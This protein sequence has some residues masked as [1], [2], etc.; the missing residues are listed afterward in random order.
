MVERLSTVPWYPAVYLGAAE[1]GHGHGAQVLADGGR[2]IVSLAAGLEVAGL[3]VGDEVFLGPERNVIVARSSAPAHVTGD[4]ASFVRYLPDGRLVV[5]IH[6]QDIIARPAACLGDSLR[7]GALLRWDRTSGL[8][9]EHLDA[10]QSIHDLLEGTPAENF[11]QVGGLQAEIARLTEAM[12]LR[13]DHPSM[14]VKYGLRAPTAGLLVGPPGVGKTLLARAFAN[15]LS[16]RTSE[17]RSRF[18]EV[19]PGQVLSHWFG[20]SETR[21]RDTFAIAKRAAASEPCV[22]IVLFFDEIDALGAARGDRGQRYNDQVL[23]TFLAELSAIEPE[24]GVF[25]L[26]ATNRLDALDPALTRP[27]GRLG[28]LVIKVPRPNRK[29]GRDVLARYLHGDLQFDVTATGG[30]NEAARQLVIDATVSAIYAPNG[31]GALAH[32]TLRDGSRRT[33]GT[34][35]LVSGAV[36][37]SVA[38]TACARAC[39]RELQTGLSGIRP[40]DVVASADEQFAELSA[41][42][43]PANVRSYVE[44]LP[45]DLDPVRVEPVKR[46]VNTSAY[47]MTA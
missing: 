43:S 7:P 21:V 14:A 6:D 38:R 27:G 29:A 15:W 13:L 24:S 9:Y 32:V 33:I 39:R 35:D 23:A 1:T 31:T 44:S 37:A 18:L 19:K 3:A 30:D 11:A 28:D 10:S 47:L 42:L 16:T 45:Q 40:D 26:A 5:R 12:H 22:P 36:L 17:G 4:T 20:Q 34:A 8:A 41:G 2:R 25:V 46:R